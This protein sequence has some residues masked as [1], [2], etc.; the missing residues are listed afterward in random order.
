MVNDLPQT[1]GV[2]DAYF[3]RANYIMYDG[4]SKADIIEDNELYFKADF[5]REP[6]IIDS[7]IYSISCRYSKNCINKMVRP[8]SVLY[9]TKETACFLK[10]LVRLL[11]IYLT[12]KYIYSLLINLYISRKKYLLFWFFL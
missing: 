4:A 7:F 9:M 3:K 1:I 8:E 12:F 11:L 10:M 2:D 6:Y 5:I